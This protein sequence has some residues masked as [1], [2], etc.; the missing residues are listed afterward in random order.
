VGQVHHYTPWEIKEIIQEQHF[1]ILLGV[2]IR[3][4]YLPIPLADTPIGV[5]ANNAYHINHP[6]SSFQLISAIY[7]LVC[8]QLDRSLKSVHHHCWLYLTWR[9]VQG[10]NIKTYKVILYKCIKQSGAELCQAQVRLCWLP[11][12]YYLFLLEIENSY[13]GCQVGGFPQL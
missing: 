13:F 12:A 5:S 11:F 9:S 8:Q 4:L 3:N 1:W 10:C 7:C 2:I 6:S